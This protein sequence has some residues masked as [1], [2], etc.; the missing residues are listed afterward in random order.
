MLVLALDTAS[1]IT[2]VAVLEYARGQPAPGSAPAATGAVGYEVCS[3]VDIAD[4]RRPAEH[5]APA[6]ERALDRAGVTMR[7][8]ELVGVGVGPGPF[9]GLRAGLVSAR[10]LGSVLRVPVIGMVSLDA[11]ALAVCGDVPVD[12][13]VATDA[14]RREVYGL[15]RRPAGAG[16]GGVVTRRR[17]AGGAARRR[18]RRGAL[19]RHPRC[20][21]R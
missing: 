12:V 17:G 21:G 3:G 7:D 11:I 9:T 20:S 14:R 1:P 19:P 6:I 10:V 8:V 16:P 2:S 15:R 5:L 13:L 4:S 18:P